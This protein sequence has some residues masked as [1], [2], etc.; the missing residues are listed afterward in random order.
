VWTNLAIVAIL[1]LFWV[2][3]GIERFLLVQLPI[4]LIGGTAGVWLFY[5]QHQFED[6][7]WEPHSS[8]DYHD[9]AMEGCSYY[10]LPRVLNWFSGTIGVHHIHHL[11][12]LVPNYLLKQC[13]D[14]VP[15]LQRVTR[16][17]LWGSWK[18]ASLKLWDPEQRKLVGFSHLKS[19]RA[20]A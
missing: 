9:A 7:Y 19:L 11:S 5:I 12:S 6:T 2:T 14:E 4:T 20:T 1:A 16:L 3:L 10:D 8:W 18:C 15:E 17:K 13:F